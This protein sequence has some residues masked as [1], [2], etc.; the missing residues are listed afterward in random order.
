MNFD[1]FIGQEKIKGILKSSL[2]SGRVSHAYS[3]EGSIGMGKFTLAKVFAGAVLCHGSSGDACGVC[4]SC[5]KLLSNSHPDFS[6]VFSEKSSIS[7]EDVRRMQEKIIIKPIESD[8]KVY[9]VDQ[10]D[11]MT[12][13][14]QNCLLKTI[15]EPPPY[16]VIILCFSNSN[17]IIKTIQSRC[18]RL[19]FSAYGREDIRL[20]IKAQGADK[21]KPI[22]FAVR[23]SQG[24]IGRAFA[25]ISD[26]FLDLRE[27]VFKV[28]N[29]I[30][31]CEIEGLIKTTEFID[32]NRNSIDDILDIIVTFYRD[33]ALY[34]TLRDENL[35]INH[36]K[37]GIILNSVSN[38]NNVNPIKA[39]K[40]IEKARMNIKTNASFQMAIDNM[41]LGLWE[42]Y[43][44]KSCRSTV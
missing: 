2:D 1:G 20:V 40:I 37:K 29:D 8:R 43:N 12:I 38:D 3:F 36:D 26:N 11:K 10:A 19:K 30:G 6:V 18:T 5:R 17:M 41:L 33:I 23:F 24:V 27:E 15:E 31:K 22:D 42:V 28:L 32:S 16:V 34:K 4:A 25:I 14:A 35:L 13:Q 21:D 9:I 39:V 7:V 44:G